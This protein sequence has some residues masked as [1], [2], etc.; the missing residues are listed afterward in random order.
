MTP[1]P[2]DRPGFMHYTFRFDARHM[3]K[4]VTQAKAHGDQH[5]AALQG[6]ALGEWRRRMRTVPHRGVPI[7]QSP[8]SLP[9]KLKD[10][11]CF[12]ADGQ[13][14]GVVGVP[15][16]T[17]IQRLISAIKTQFTPGA[18]RE[19]LG[20]CSVFAVFLATSVSDEAE[21]F[22]GVIVALAASLR[23]SPFEVD[24]GLFQTIDDHR[25]LEE[26][27]R[28][29]DDP[30]LLAKLRPERSHVALVFQ[31]KGVSTW[32]LAR[33]M[34]ARDKWAVCCFEVC[35]AEKLA[36]RLRPKRLAATQRELPKLYVLWDPS[37][38]R[39]GKPASSAL[40]EWLCAA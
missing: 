9:T 2:N 40:P 8:V 16:V 25:L 21:R 31:N 29:P 33:M 38:T 23:N 14:C 10:E 7:V 6:L 5:I 34:E 13:V 26:L 18:Q 36:G 39:R 32:D 15:I 35:A 12:R 22:S 30:T 37:R 17:T 1:C 11:M 20:S 28:D 19:A 27:H 3:A 4:H 24:W